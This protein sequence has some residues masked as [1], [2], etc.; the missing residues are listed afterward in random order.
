MEMLKFY[1]ELH[2]YPAASLL[3]HVFLY[4]PGVGH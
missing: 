3:V 4:F 2:T 1:T